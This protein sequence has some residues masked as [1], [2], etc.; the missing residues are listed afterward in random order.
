MQPSRSRRQPPAGG[1]DDGGLASGREGGPLP[2][3]VRGSDRRFPGA[4]GE[5]KAGRAGYAPA[6]ANEWVTG[7]C[8]KPR[9]KCGEC[10]NQAFI[11][12]SDDV[13]E[14][15][16]RGEDQVRPRSS[17]SRFRGRGL[18][19]LP[20][21]TCRFLPPTSTASWARDAVAYLETCRLQG[22]PAALERSRSGQGGHAWIFFAEPV[23]AREARQLGATLLTATMER[24]PEIGFASYDRLFPSQDT[25]P[26]GGFGNLIALPLQRRARAGQQPVRRRRLWAF[27]DQWAFLASLAAWTEPR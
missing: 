10:P 12:V 23:P 17:R 11:P 16:L 5:R 27:D 6:C 9:V 8:G 14:G 4:L 22:I 25:M 24:R 20:D 15:H 7:I 21:E 2:G 18:S 19:L 13:I 1:T 3:S 26:A